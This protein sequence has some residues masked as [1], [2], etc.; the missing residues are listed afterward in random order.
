MKQM[1]RHRLAERLRHGPYHRADLIT[2][3][4]LLGAQA[5]PWGRRA[6]LT[7]WAE[8]ARGRAGI[9]RSFFL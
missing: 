2:S 4:D 7:G 9:S 5:E 6:Q 3:P 1:S 8:V